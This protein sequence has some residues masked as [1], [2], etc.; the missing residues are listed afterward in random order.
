MFAVHSQRLGEDVELIFCKLVASPDSQK[1]LYSLLSPDE[2]TRA[3]GFRFDKHRTSFIIARSLLRILLGNVTDAQPAAIAFRYGPEGKPVLDGAP[4][5]HFNVSHSDDLVLYGLRRN[6]EIGVDIERIRDIDDLE[7]IA[8]QFF[9]PAECRELLT[10]SKQDRTKA[11]FDCWT[12]KE[13]FIKFLGT[14][15][16][17]PL[18]RF[19]VTLTPGD[20]ARLVHV[21]GQWPGS[22]FLQDVAPSDGY[23]A[24]VASEVRNC[25]FRVWRLEQPEDGVRFLK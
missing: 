8:K 12:R 3:A 20:P 24:A 23:A 6:H 15:L 13:A 11:F 17:F 14:G 4:H 7:A 2:R 25:R 18:L 19:Q 5:V 16:S 22:W 1:Y 10:V 21:D 9:C